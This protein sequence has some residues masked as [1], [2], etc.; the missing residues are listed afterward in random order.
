MHDTTKFFLGK[1]KVM[2]KALGKHAEDEF[3]DNTAQLSR[4]LSG[5]VCLAFSNLGHKEFEKKISEYEVED[6][7]QAGQ[8]ATYSVFLEKGQEAL[9]DYGHSMETQFRQLGLPT[10][11]NF[12]KIELE[13]D[14]YVCKIG[15]VLS[16]EQAKLLKLL[17]HKMSKF[18]LKVLVHRSAKGKISRTDF[19]DEYLTR[20]KE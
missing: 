16:V 15:T 5:Q 8:K 19:G 18:T 3:E 20:L 17:S 12:Q 11:L 4:Y 14:V 9:K 1:N 7:A 13:Q 10:K 6:Y 2:I